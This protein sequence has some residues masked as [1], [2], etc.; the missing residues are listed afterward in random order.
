[1]HGCVSAQRPSVGE[2]ANVRVHESKRW[3]GFNKSM[4]ACMS[5]CVCVRECVCVC[6]RECVQA[7]LPLICDA[8]Y[9]PAATFIE[10]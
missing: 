5:A 1:M 4:S 2:C 7:Y 6:V 10:S 9:D 8:F 3:Y